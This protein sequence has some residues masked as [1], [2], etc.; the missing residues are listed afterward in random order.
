LS[1]TKEDV[2][3]YITR[4]CWAVNIFDRERS[5]EGNDGVEIGVDSKARIRLNVRNGHRFF[6]G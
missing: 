5:T 6:R 3:K 4:K 1:Q 2:I